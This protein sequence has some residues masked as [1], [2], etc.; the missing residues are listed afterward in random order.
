MYNKVLGNRQ[1]L[2]GEGERSERVER[3][4]VGEPAVKKVEFRLAKF[5]CS[6]VMK[7]YGQ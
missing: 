7:S 4:K 2:S 6:R 1:G 3:R 5:H